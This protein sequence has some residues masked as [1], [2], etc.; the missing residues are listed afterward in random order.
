MKKSLYLFTIP[1][2][3]LVTVL[4]VS[5]V[6]ASQASASQNRTLNDFFSRT[7]S[8]QADF[9]QMV[10]NSRGKVLEQSHGNLVI[11]RPDKFILD[12]QTP[13]EQKYISNGKTIW[14]YDVELEQVNIKPL[15]EQVGDSPALLLSSNDNIYKYYQVDNVSMRKPDGLNWIQ[16]K[17]L[18]EDMTFERVLLAFKNHILMRMRMYDSF[19]QITELKFSNISVNKPFAARQFDFE[20]PADVDIIGRAN[21]Q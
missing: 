4:L 20:P 8:L 11:S 12:Y 2:I 21:A 15:D 13:V 1:A 16:L 7:Q 19:G 17:A 10:M 14:I 9:D 3:F 18:N 6:Q 5:I